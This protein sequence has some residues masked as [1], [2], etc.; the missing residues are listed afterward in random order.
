MASR[1]LFQSEP[2]AWHAVPGAPKIVFKIKHITSLMFQPSV[3]PRLTFRAV[4]FS[5]ITYVLTHIYS[6][7]QS[8]NVSFSEFPLWHSRL[9]IQLQ[10]LRSLQR[11]GFDPR[12][13]AVGSRI[14]HCL[15]CCIGR[16]CILDSIPGLGTSICF[17]CDHY[18]KKKSPFL[19]TEKA[20]MGELKVIMIVFK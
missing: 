14:W 16:S 19:Q 6:L 20:L 5:F 8:Q 4:N 7:L 11:Y 10:Q 2:G 17:R 18:K 15:S 9:R 1:I 13:S 12:P 3:I